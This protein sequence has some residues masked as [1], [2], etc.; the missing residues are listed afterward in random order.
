VFS[1]KP[2]LLAHLQ[3]PPFIFDGKFICSFFTKPQGISILLSYFILQFM[4]SPAGAAV[5]LLFC[6]IILTVITNEILGLLFNKNFLYISLIPYVFLLGLMEKYFFPFETITSLLIVLLFFYIFIKIKGK[7]IIQ[8]TLAI[9]LGVLTYYLTGSGFYLVFLTLVLLVFLISEI[10]LPKKIISII[11]IVLLYWIVPLITFKYLFA[12]PPK[13]KYL[14]FFQERPLFISYNPKIFFYLFVF[15]L[16]ILIILTKLI[17]QSKLLDLNKLVSKKVA[18]ISIFLIIVFTGI[19]VKVNYDSQHQKVILCD[20]YTYKGDWERAMQT[21]IGSPEYDYKTNVNFNRAIDHLGKFATNFFDYPQYVG[22]QSLYPDFYYN[23]DIS[24]ISADYYY[25][26]GYI[27][28]AKLWAYESL[29]EFPY[30]RRALQSLVPIHLVLGE[31]DAA[32]NILNLLKKGIGNKDF[33]KKYTPYVNDTSLVEK[34]FEFSQKRAFMPKEKIVSKNIL[35]RLIHLLETNSKNVRAY[36]HL[37]MFYLLSLNLRNFENMIQYYNLYYTEK[38]PV[39]FEEA[40]MIYGTI[41]NKNV[42][43]KYPVSDETV[44][45]FIKFSNVLKQY[46]DLPEMAGKELYNEFFNSYFYYSKFTNPIINQRKI[47]VAD[48]E[49]KL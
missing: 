12:L 2:H 1:L 20:Y 29:I 45:R 34:N 36:E 40:L 48:E 47:V 6:G 8:I 14:L 31:Y 24:F 4:Y 22:N 25:D 27:T 3:Q 41:Y 39:L 32:A 42:K 49:N 13:E 16:P 37:Q 19:F 21:A 30:S 9:I 23:A 26:L 10:D 46:H 43:D 38:I 35:E 18:I 44:S 33:V 28:E 11:T 15:S 17:I 5:I 7:Y